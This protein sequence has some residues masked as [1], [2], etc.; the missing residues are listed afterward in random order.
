VLN[1]ITYFP[2]YTKIFWLLKRDVL[3][4]SF[5]LHSQNNYL[6]LG[7]NFLCLESEGIF[8]ITLLVFSLLLG[9]MKDNFVF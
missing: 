4:L 9:K 5:Y 6:P 7:F 1:K 3:V 8:V 2:L